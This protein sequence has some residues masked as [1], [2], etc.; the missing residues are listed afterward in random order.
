MVSGVRWCRGA[1]R[2]LL[3]LPCWQHKYTYMPTRTSRVILNL[4]GTTLSNARSPKTCSR[5]TLLEE[6]GG[7]GVG[8][9]VSERKLLEANGT[10]IPQ[11]I[12]C[13]GA[14][15]FKRPLSSRILECV[16]SFFL[17]AGTKKTEIP[18]FA[19]EMWSS[20]WVNFMA[21]ASLAWAGGFIWVLRI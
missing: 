1:V 6:L 14:N 12:Y 19:H 13:R 5:T 2:L 11:R 18:C 10:A 9:G 16:E 8:K 20:K 15:L 21:H 4:T 7:G 17:F 3:G